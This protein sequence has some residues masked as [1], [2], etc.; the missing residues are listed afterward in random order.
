M[1]DGV[2]SIA[3][4]TAAAAAD[5]DTDLPLLHRALDDA[6]LAHQ[7]VLWDDPGVDWSSYGVLLIRSTWDYV[8]RINDFLGWID[9]VAPLGTLHNPA[10]ALRWSLDKHYLGEMAALGIPT[11]PT[12]YVAPHDPANATLPAWAADWVVVK[13]TISAGSR[14]TDRYRSGE[15][16][17]IEAHVRRITESGRTAMIQ[18]YLDR[19]DQAGETAML[20]F[21]AA[22][23]HAARKGPLLST[24]RTEVAGLYLREE[25]S[26]RLP[27]P[28]ELSV[29]D[30]VNRWITRRF[31]PLTYARIDL[32]PHTDG[33]MVLE[34]ELV[35]PS[36]FLETEP[37]AAARLVATLAA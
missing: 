7:L 24:Q 17:A 35:E 34:V 22:F 27:S 30:Q 18:P 37:G 23:S 21:G 36:L 16:Q 25:I 28:E 33:P 19:V 12:V 4:I 9:R 3:V 15:T 5:N 32:L 8:E 31:G 29:A 26:A 1:N 6:G 14:D 2:T 13:P 10:P 11:V 20:Y